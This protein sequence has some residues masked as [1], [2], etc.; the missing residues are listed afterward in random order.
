MHIELV[1][2]ISSINNKIS[3]YPLTS[4]YHLGYSVF[5]MLRLKSER[6]R[7]GIKQKALAKKVGISQATYSSIETGDIPPKDIVL[8]RLADVLGWQE[9][10]LKLLEVI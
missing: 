7:L 8:K 10:P 5:H 3:T 1:K 6:G 2:G 9:D 4:S